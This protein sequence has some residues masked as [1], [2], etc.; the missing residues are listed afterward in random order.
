MHHAMSANPNQNLR[1]FPGTTTCS[2]EIHCHHRNPEMTRSTRANHRRDEEVHYGRQFSWKTRRGHP[3]A[4]PGPAQRTS[5]AEPAANSAGDAEPPANNSR[6]TPP[7][8]HAE[9]LQA[10]QVLETELDLRK[11]LSITPLDR[12]LEFR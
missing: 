5:E 9:D 7:G 12:P 2:C 8:L 4:R 3:Y 11:L 10:F 1:L 6:S